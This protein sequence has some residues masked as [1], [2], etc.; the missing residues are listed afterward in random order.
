M[1]PNV[2]HFVFGLTEQREP[3][4]PLHYAS[5][6]SCRRVI[7]PERIYFHHKHLPW[8]PYWER[9]RSHLVLVEVD[10]V[11]EVLAADYSA[12]LVPASYR[13]AH[14]SDFIRLDALIEHGG[15]YA[16]IDTIFVNR[17]APELFA[18]PFVIGRESP[19]VDELSGVLRP[20]LCNALL[21]AEPGARFARAWR[22]T[23]ASELNG[24]WSNHSG[25]LS[26]RLSHERPDEVSV[27]EAPTF[28]PFAADR[29]GLAAL[30]EEHHRVEAGTVSVHLWAH[31]WWSRDR[32]D[33]SHVHEGW[34]TPSYLRRAQT[35]LA[36]LAR[37][38]L[39]SSVGD[40]MVRSEGAEAS[41]PAWRYLSLD[42]RSGYGVAADRARLALE[43][44]GLVVDWVPFVPGPVWQLGYQP[45]EDLHRP[46]GSPPAPASS[47]G[48]GASEA[49]TPGRAIEGGVVVAHLVPEYLP[50][51]RRSCPDSF[52]VAHTVWETDRLPAHW[53]A[54]LETADLVVVPSRFSAEVMSRELAGA[55]EIVPHVA[56]DVTAP[57][58]GSWIDVPDE[59][60]VFYTVAE[61]ND[62]KAVFKTVEAFLQAFSD[63][64]DVVLIV[65]TSPAD[66]R[67]PLS[68]AAGAFQPGTSAFALAQLIAGRDRIPPIRLVTRQLSDPEMVALHRRGDCFVS[69]CRSEG[70]GLGAFDAAA[71]G[72]PVVT[73][74][75]GGHLDYLGGSPYLVDY[76]L[77]AVQGGSEGSSYTSDQRWAEPNLE[78]AVALLR[79][80]AGHRSEV[81]ERAAP[82]AEEI[83]WRYRPAAVAHTLRSAVERHQRAPRRSIGGPSDQRP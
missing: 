67:F 33:M 19:V 31:L 37:P 3:F 32:V 12:G 72:K 73:T 24:T 78:H 76:E 63:G 82:L 45:A 21:L 41:S 39:I 68:S 35:T 25:F 61:W 53:P 47:S 77:V 18:A 65:K 50:E 28:F 49:G 58:S 4:H 62:R 2:A 80:I 74:G 29:A 16:D 14:H 34:C 75:F 20:S 8:G 36:E 59:V 5:L 22:D 30:L 7:A 51:I 71:F 60:F 52:L 66:R 15:I 17:P 23:M 13:Y 81:A 38:Y 40:P 27:V 64:D 56:P 69:L 43:G 9:I 70:W 44:S 46:G 55:I 42:E 1:I 6:E 83:R 57:T 11:E 26:E 54:C 48:G 79:E 10:L